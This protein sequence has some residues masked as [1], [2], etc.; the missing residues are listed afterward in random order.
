[1]NLLFV[2]PAYEPAWNLGGIVRALSVLC[3]GLAGQ[4]HQVT[5]Y[6]LNVNGKGGT[7][8]L[9]AD[10]PV[11]QGGVLSYFFPS[12][13]GPQ[14]LWDSRAL[15]QRLHRT[16]KD[17]DL[18]YASAIWQW[19]GVAT[20]AVC[21]RYQVP[22]VIGTHGSFAQ[23]LM[24]RHS[25]R[26]TLY[27]R[28]FLKRSLN[29]ATAL[30]FTTTYEKR[31]SAHLLGDYQSF[32]VPN[33][34]DCQFFRPKKGNR[35]AFRDH[36]GIPQDAPVIITVGRADPKKRVD[37]LIQSLTF[38]P[39]LRLLVVGP[40]SYHLMGQWQKL[41]ISLGVANRVHRTGHLE[42]ED[43]VDAYNAAD[44]FS[45]ISVDE[46]F[47]NVV[48]EAMACGLPIL[49]S[50]GV[51]S[52]EEVIDQPVGKMVRLNQTEIVAALDDFYQNRDLWAQ[53]GENAV[54]VARTRF[55]AENVAKLMAQEFQNLSK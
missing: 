3:R 42:G 18:V 52:G 39:K 44:L 41:A 53:W 46:N 13:F 16:A 17:F 49:V 34:I 4:G 36:H 33:A 50:E 9:P 32:V 55:S 21:H 43:L 54:K 2:T 31:M 48:I 8:N 28:A 6:A 45:L 51:G 25:W 11:D 7:L 1:L 37:L 29:R 27:W 22:L 40:D 24:K 35:Q 12:T 14:S 20:A 30:H 19:L 47:G 26:K 15:L 38:L 23:P 5:V 10:Q